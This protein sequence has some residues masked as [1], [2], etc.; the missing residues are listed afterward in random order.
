MMGRADH[1]SAQLVALA[2]KFQQNGMHLTQI[3]HQVWPGHLDLSFIEP[4]LQI[5]FQA[6]GQETGDNMAEQVSSG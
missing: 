4:L 6:Q 5:D 2:I 1:I 3:P